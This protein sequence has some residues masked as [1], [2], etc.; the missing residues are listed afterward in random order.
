MFL[1]LAARHTTSPL[2]FDAIL[3]QRQPQIN[4]DCGFRQPTRC[5]AQR[6]PRLGGKLFFFFSRRGAEVAEGV[7]DPGRA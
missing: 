4:Q 5:P 1:K 3:D 6:P 2:R 7:G